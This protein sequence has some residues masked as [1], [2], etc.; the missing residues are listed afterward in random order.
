MRVWYGLLFCLFSTFSTAAWAKDEFVLWKR[1]FDRPELFEIIQLAA[2]LTREEYGDYQITSSAEFEQ[3]RAFFYLGEGEH[4]N[5]VVGGMDREREE[6]H[7]PVYIP[8][9]RGLLG[10]RLCLTTPDK[11]TNFKEVLTLDDFRDS[12]LSIGVGSHW[13]D[14]KIL[15]KNE[16]LSI[17]VPVYQHLFDMLE[18]GRFDCFLRSISEVDAELQVVQ[19]RGIE[20]ESELAFVYPAADFLFVSKKSPRLQERLEKGLI[21]AVASGQFQEYFE[22]YHSDKLMKHHFF[23]RRFL[24]LSN[25]ELSEKAKQAINRYGVASFAAGL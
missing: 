25:R 20:A 6:K 7:L 22:K 1:N 15:N 12:N 19:D 2:E 21:Q 5:V 13:P 4:L 8:V 10:F 11:F 14:R 18:V 3:G 24:F 9:D 16:L 23:T 17:N